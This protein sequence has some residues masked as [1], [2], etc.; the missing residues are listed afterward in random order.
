MTVSPKKIRQGILDAMW[1]LWAYAFVQL[2][3]LLHQHAILPTL[4]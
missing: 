3:D 4:F 2:L 1:Y